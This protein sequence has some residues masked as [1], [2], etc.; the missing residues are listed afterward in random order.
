LISK[1]DAESPYILEDLAEKYFGLVDGVW[2][3]DLG[4]AI[5]TDIMN[6]DALGNINQI[7]NR[8]ISAF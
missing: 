4:E 1:G 6:L 5:Y 2:N 3:A 7:T 8:M